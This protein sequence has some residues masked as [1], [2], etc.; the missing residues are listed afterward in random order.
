MINIR[1]VSKSFGMKQ[2]L[3][4]INLDIAPGEFATLVGP[5]G[6]GKTTL[7]RIIATLL[8]PNSGQV[9]VDGLDLN[10]RAYTV[11]QLLGVVSHQ[12]LLYD[13]LTA[14]ENLFFYARLYNIND[15]VQ[16]IN[17]VLDKVDL[18]AW[19]DALV[20][21]FS[22]GMQQRLS[23]ARALLHNPRV[24]LFDEPHTGLDQNNSIRLD[25]ILQSTVLS[26]NTVLMITHDLKHALASSHKIAVLHKG[27]IAYQGSTANMSLDAFTYKYHEIIDK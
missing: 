21:T 18:T 7:L 15:Y 24:I 11:R 12:T 26:G 16:H 17:L 4:D 14:Y 27:K 22:H 23:I 6:S 2:V 9:I 8:R 5:N 13:N 25:E 10:T 19:K 1:S 3:R 20:G